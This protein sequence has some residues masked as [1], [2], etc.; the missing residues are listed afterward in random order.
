MSQAID[1]LQ[2]EKARQGTDIAL[3]AHGFPLLPQPSI[4][5]DDP[6][7]RAP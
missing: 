1:D 6:L 4:H 7:V 3:D 2:D 5:K